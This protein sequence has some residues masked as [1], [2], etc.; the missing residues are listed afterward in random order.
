MI[1]KIS[2]LFILLIFISNCG[3]K[4][5][6][7]EDFYN[8]NIT[9]IQVSGDK[10]IGF[11]IKNNLTRYENEN[12][13]K[14]ELKINV[15]KIKSIKEKDIGNE[16]T[17]YEILIKAKIEFNLISK[18]QNGT[19][20]ITSKGNYSVQNQYS[21]TLIQERNLINNLSEKI[22]EEVQENLSNL[23]NDS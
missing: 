14:I 5:V 2:Q 23:V 13:E 9:N 6:N 11:T 20:T 1:K 3:F 12:K 17:K 15:E 19:F 4:V 8:F 7:N 16:I 18:D 10:K 22:I 21:Q